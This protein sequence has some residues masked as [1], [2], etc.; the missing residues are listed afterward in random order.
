MSFHFEFVSSFVQIVV[1]ER[2]D[3][4]DNDFLNFRDSEPDC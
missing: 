2:F 3:K 4:F 1:Q